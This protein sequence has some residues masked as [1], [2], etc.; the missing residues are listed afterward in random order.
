MIRGWV[1]TLLVNDFFLGSIGGRGG[2]FLLV[3]FTIYRRCCFFFLQFLDFPEL[4]SA[5]K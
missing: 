5:Q 4:F 2:G 1:F 3:F